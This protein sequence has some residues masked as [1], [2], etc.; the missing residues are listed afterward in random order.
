MNSKA[1]PPQQSQQY[2]PQQYRRGVGV[3]L[4]NGEGQVFIGKRIDVKTSAG[5]WQMPQ[6]GIHHK[7][8]LH[9]KSGIHHKGG[10]H[11]K[12]GIHHKG[13][14]LNKSESPLAAAKRELQEETGICS[15][16]EPLATT[17]WLRYELPDPLAKTLWQGRFKGQEQKWFAFRFEGSEQEINLAHH[18][19][20]EFV[21]WQWQAPHKLPALAVDFKRPLYRR[22]LKEFAHLIK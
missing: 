12:G 22:L 7:G 14:F 20:P 5:G 3:F 15:I 4:L 21:S 13:G 17:C 11:N 8:G 1:K 6:G 18:K 16:S 2:P 10:F 9:N 19:K